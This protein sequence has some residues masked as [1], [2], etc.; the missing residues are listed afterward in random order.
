MDNLRFEDVPQAVELVLQKLSLLEKEISEI[1][2]N[3][4]PKEPTVLMTRTETAEFLKISIS[5]LWHW[6][7]KGIVPSYG[8]GNRVYYKRSDIEASLYKLS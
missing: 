1:K 4:Q 2:T 6:S 3:F 8:I 7:K 5:T